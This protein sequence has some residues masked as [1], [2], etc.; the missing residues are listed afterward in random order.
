MSFDKH[1]AMN[2]NQ[3]TQVSKIAKKLNSSINGLSAPVLQFIGRNY[4]FPSDKVS[5]SPST[6]VGW[7]LSLNNYK[8]ANASEA[9]KLC[10]QR[11]MQLVS[12]ET[13]EEATNIA[14]FMESIGYLATYSAL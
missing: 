7:F 3:S 13:Q 12:I 4:I 9:A 10:T 5:S 8:K 1:L 11:G 2:C 6:I 14:S